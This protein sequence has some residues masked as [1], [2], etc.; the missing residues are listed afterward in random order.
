[1]KD[2]SEDIEMFNSYINE[3]V[4]DGRLSDG[5]G[6]HTPKLK[7]RGDPNKRLSYASYFEENDI[8]HVQPGTKM[9]YPGKGE[10][11]IV[12]VDEKSQTATVELPDEVREFNVPWD[13]LQT[14]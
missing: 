3:N 5:I 4:M 11:N 8:V 2:Y 1:M 13:L 6:Q 14:L 10:V 7:R 12:D 9:E